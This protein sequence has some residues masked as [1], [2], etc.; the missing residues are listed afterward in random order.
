MHGEARQVVP[1][2]DADRLPALRGRCSIARH[3][4]CEHHACASHPQPFTYATAGRRPTRRCA[5]RPWTSAIT[6][7]WRVI[8]DGRRWHDEVFAGFVLVR[9][10]GRICAR[11]I[12]RRHRTPGSAALPRDA[13]E[14][15]IGV[16]PTGQ[17]RP[18]H[19]CCY[20]AVG[21][22]IASEP[23]D[24]VTMRHARHGT[25]EGQAGR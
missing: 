11:P 6:T 10:P 16:P 14:V 15:G 17:A 1:A 13:V 24:R 25:D 18:D 9:R 3:T 2:G 23:G 12:R 8:R 19:V 22:A 4:A 5:T 20:D 21:D 7:R